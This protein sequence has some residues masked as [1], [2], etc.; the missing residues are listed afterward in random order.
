MNDRDLLR[1]LCLAG[2]ALLFGAQALRYPLGGVTRA[3]PGLFPLAVSVLLLL[4]AVLTLVRGR[5]AG[6]AP[7]R[8]SPRNVGLIVLSLV[9]FAVLSRY[10]NMAAGIVALVLCASSAARPWSLRRSAL[11]A[12]CL[13]GIAFAFQHLFGLELHLY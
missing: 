2:I 8:F 13:L 12:A 4:V 7:L 10:V 11:V 5:F 3:G 6:R 9:I 1:G